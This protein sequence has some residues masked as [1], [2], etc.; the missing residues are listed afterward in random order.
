M[1]I[2]LV[3][4]D[5]GFIGQHLCRALIDTRKYYVVG[6]D[7]KRGKQ[8]DILTCALPEVDVCFHLAGQ[9]DARSDDV[10]E[11][12]RI[13]IMGTLRILQR[14]GS[15]VVFAATYPDIRPIVPYAIAKQACAYYCQ[16]YGARMVHQCNITGPGGHGVIEAFEKADVLKIAGDGKQKRTYASVHLAVAAFMEMANAPP[17]ASCILPGVDLTV[18]DI[19]E[20]FFPNKHRE[21]IPLGANDLKTWQ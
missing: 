7:W 15:R 4:G 20:I 10:I 11:D 16:L 2:A 21:F 19:A 8:E 9:T 1:P 3:T 17:G 18:L 14:Y 6:L 13:N 12:A 5:L